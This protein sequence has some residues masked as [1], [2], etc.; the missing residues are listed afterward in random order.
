MIGMRGRILSLAVALVVAA[1]GLTLRAPQAPSLES[2]LSVP[3]AAASEKAVAP[4]GARAATAR[5][6]SVDEAMRELDLIRPSRPK[7][8]DDFTIPTAD[9]KSFKLSAH[10]G[11]PILINFWATWCPPCLEEMPAMERLWRAQKEAGF[12]MLAVAVDS[13]PKLIA[14]FLER[15]GLTFVV[16]LDTK[17]EL[18]NAYGV[19]ALPS[20]FVVDREGKLAGLAIGPRTWDNTAAHALFER[21]AR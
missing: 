1:G 4:T 3:L 12:V 9:G 13:N 10:R 19:R 18:A 17:M 7:L 16:G 8:A 20:S 21:L 15:H 6:F 14:P 5:T 11:R 2:V